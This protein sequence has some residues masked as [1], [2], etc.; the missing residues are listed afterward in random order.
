MNHRIEVVGAV[1]IAEGKILCTQRSEHMKM[2]HLWE[3]P[4]GKVEDG[5]SFAEALVREIREELNC[6]IEVGKQI[7]RT[8]HVNSEASIILNTFYCKLIKDRPQL[9]EHEDMCWL[10]PSELG[11]LSWATADLPTVEILIQSADEF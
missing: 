5:E 8:S 3:F 9:M 4:G 10:P 1:I 7:A 11:K 2:S 6:S